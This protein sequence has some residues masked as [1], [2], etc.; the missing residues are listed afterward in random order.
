V[1]TR[2]P[3]VRAAELE[4]QRAARTNLA[5]GHAQADEHAERGAVERLARQ[6]RP[7]DDPLRVRL[8][9]ADARGER[10]S[11]AQR[12]TLGHLKAQHDAHTTT[13]QGSP[14]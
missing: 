11:P 7:A 9:Q 4:R 10:L 5:A 14:R 13:T 1:T 3:P 12:M 2:D 8:E 6:Y